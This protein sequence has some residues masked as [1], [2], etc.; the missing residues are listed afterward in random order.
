MTTRQKDALRWLEQVGEANQ[1][2]V[3]RAG[4]QQRTLDALVEQGRVVLRVVQGRVRPFNVY[5]HPDCALAM[6]VMDA[7]EDAR[8]GA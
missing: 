7:H 2:A 4:Y 6:A 1:F 8:V 5:Q 3:H